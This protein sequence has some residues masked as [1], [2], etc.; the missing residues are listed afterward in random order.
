MVEDASAKRTHW[1]VYDVQASVRDIPEEASAGD[2]ATRVGR[3]VLGNSDLGDEFG[4]MPE[5]MGEAMAEM[6]GGESR[7]KEGTNSFGERHYHGAVVGDAPAKYVF[8]V[9][10]LNAMLGL[11]AGAAKAEVTAAMRGKVLGK[12]QLVA[13]TRPGRGPRWAKK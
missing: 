4:D 10:A 5:G 1:L 8:K 12:A 2:G 6:D 11:P 3:D 7:T 9:F 13:Y